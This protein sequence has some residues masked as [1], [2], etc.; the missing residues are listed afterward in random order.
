MI[1]LVEETLIEYGVSF[2]KLTKE[3]FLIEIYLLYN[4][5][6]LRCSI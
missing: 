5:I 3:T 4:I 1:Q 6:C 2:P